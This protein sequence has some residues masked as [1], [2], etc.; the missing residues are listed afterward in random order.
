MIVSTRAK[1]IIE[2]LLQID[3]FIKIGEIAQKIETTQRTVY[4]SMDEITA[5]LSSCQLQ[6]ESKEGKGI[7]IIKEASNIEKLKQLLASQVQENLLSM[8]QRVSLMILYLLHQEEMIKTQELANQLKVSLATIRNDL[9]LMKEVLKD[10]QLTLDSKKGSGIQITGNEIAKRQMIVKIIL[11]EVGVEVSYDWIF[12]QQQNKQNEFLRILSNFGYHFYVHQ[13]YLLIEALI[14]DDIDDAS[15]VEFILL[16]SILIMRHDKGNTITIV[17]DLKQDSDIVK[18]IT[19]NIKEQLEV[20]FNIQ[21]YESEVE[22][23]RWLIGLNLY[24]R[25]PKSLFKLSETNLYEKVKQLVIMV[26]TKLGISIHNDDVLMNGLLS[27][28]ERAFARVYNNMFL[29]NPM[30]KNIKKDYAHVYEI[31]NSSF[32]TIFEDDFPEDEI[33][34]LVLYFVVAIDKLMAKSASV[35]VICT[36]GMG[37]SKLL[38]NRL[39]AE[40]VEVHVKKVISL[41]GLHHENIDDYDLII[42]T[43]PLDVDSE[44]CMVVSPLLSVHEV[45]AIKHKIAMKRSKIIHRNAKITRKVD[46]KSESTIE[47]LKRM[48]QLC[49]WGIHLIEKFKV[50]A[51]KINNEYDVLTQIERY[52]IENEKIIFPKSNGLHHV[53][54]QQLFEIPNTKIIYVEF[55]IKNLKAP[56]FLEFILKKDE[57]SKLDIHGEASSANVIILILYPEGGLLIQELLSALAITIIDSAYTIQIFEEGMQNKIQDL[58]SAKIRNFL[59]NQL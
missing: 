50:I 39:E 54:H 45:E 26:E 43:V 24:I 31:I 3:H 49:E 56:V 27:H 4:R 23:L 53:N 13:V 44:K 47:E 20:I 19:R 29:S 30:K 34:Y 25:N 32:S 36:S 11:M 59:A 17:N 18:Q 33:A 15:T 12:N 48:N 21:F 51:L 6:L 5:I 40:I 55:C 37:S 7:R 28:L 1:I 35:L 2:Y 14:N 9:H 16:V 57:K 46:Y 22:Y 42:S 52:L 38:A 8:R 41:I 10:A 58:I